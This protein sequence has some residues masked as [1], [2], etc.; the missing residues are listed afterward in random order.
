MNTK[1]WLFPVSAVVLLTAGAVLRTRLFAYWQHLSAVNYEFQ[2]TFFCW[3]LAF[4]TEIAFG[5]VLCLLV[6]H[7]SPRI[8][9]FSAVHFVLFLLLCGCFW[10]AQFYLL[11]PV[12]S[13]DQTLTAILNTLAGV[14]L[15]QASFRMEGHASQTGRNQ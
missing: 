8:R 15:F 12:L 3:C 6:T 11:Y 14:L 10:A 9:R 1:K 13:P 5:F 2:W 7:G 4:I